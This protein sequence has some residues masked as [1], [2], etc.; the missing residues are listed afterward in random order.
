MDL[1]EMFLN[2]PFY[3][4][5]QPYSGVDVTPYKEELNIPGEGASWLHW[6]RPSPYNVVLFYYLAEEFI[7]GNP[8]DRSNPFVWDKL[9]LNLPGLA[10][11]DPTRPKVIKWDSTKN[12]IACDLVVFVDDLKGS[13]PTVELTWALT[14]TVASRIQYLGIQEASRTRRT[15]TRSPGAWA[16]GVFSTSATNVFVSVSQDKWD[17]AK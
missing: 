8:C 16:G 6:S 2:F 13:G 4:S 7:C 11:F 3:K 17:K 14:R 9:V 1:G 5:L 12:W 10:M 15:P